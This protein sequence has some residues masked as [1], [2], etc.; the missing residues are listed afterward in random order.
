[1]SVVFGLLSKSNS[2]QTDP[3]FPSDARLYSVATQHG[4]EA[5]HASKHSWE[6]RFS[7]VLK[8]STSAQQPLPGASYPTSTQ[9]GRERR[10]LS[11]SS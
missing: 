1:M 7:M 11:D 4:S 9:S 3:R 2:L 6:L 10:L 8:G 5:S